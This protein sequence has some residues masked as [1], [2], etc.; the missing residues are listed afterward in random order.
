MDHIGPGRQVLSLKK[1]CYNHCHQDRLLPFGD[2]ICQKISIIRSFLA[3]YTAAIANLSTQGEAAKAG[4]RT[5]EI[6]A[7]AAH[8]ILTSDS[9]TFTGHFCVDDEVLWTE[10]VRD[11]TKYNCQHGND[12]HFGFGFSIRMLKEYSTMNV[13]QFV[14]ETA[15]Q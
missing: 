3:I 4:C 7:D 1:H 9:K 6:M 5:A 14:L 8:V 11:F 13:L 10:G 2:L 12:F 15:H